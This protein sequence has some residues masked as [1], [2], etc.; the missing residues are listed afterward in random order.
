M[1]VKGFVVEV[2][3]LLLPVPIFQHNGDKKPGA[4][5]H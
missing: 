3:L 5:D 1:T 2:F 4:K